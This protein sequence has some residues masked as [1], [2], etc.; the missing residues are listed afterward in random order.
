MLKQLVVQL[1]RFGDIVQTRRLALSLQ[2]SGETQLCVDASLAPLARLVYPGLVVH[3][4]PAH[5]ASAA[6][7]L[8]RGRQ[9]FA[10]LRAER[11]DAVYII[12]HAGLSRAIAPLFDPDIVRGYPVACG[13]PLRSNWMRLA[14]RWMEDRAA[15]PLHIAD[16]WAALAPELIAPGRVN[17][18]ARPG[19]KGLGVVLSGQNARRSL[20]P[21]TLAPVVRAVFDRLGG[22]RVFLL[23]N[24]AEEA[25][26]RALM[27][28][29]PA[30][31]AGRCVN[32]AGK[33]DWPGL[34][35]ALTGLDCL[36]SPDTGT[37]HLAAHLGVPVEGLYCSSAWAF[38]T[39]PY[40]LGH[41]VWQ[42][43][44]DCAP[45]TE[46]VPCPRGAFCREAYA[47]PAT[48]ARMQ[49]RPAKRPLEGLA[50]LESSFDAFGLVWNAVSE[51]SA[52]QDAHAGRRASLR[53]LLAEYRGERSLAPGGATAFYQEADWMLPHALP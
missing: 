35:D 36:L 28:R 44:P 16:F 52:G 15:S 1:A 8:I 42:A 25:A 10:A 40:G 11:F 19:G 38:E 13:Q 2:Q 26:G 5:G 20:P 23:G 53:A 50:L 24:A 33:T 3:G 27:A 31:M 37:A 30:Q 39:G 21:E 41:R 29:L 6:D 45:C 43:A 51:S 7:V 46:S 48:L 4:L 14:F 12:N 18:V 32:L 47:A 17:P 22:P 49:G 9:T 34:A